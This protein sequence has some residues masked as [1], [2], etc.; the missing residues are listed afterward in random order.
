[1]PRERLFRFLTF[2]QGAFPIVYITRELFALL[3][4]GIV[5]FDERGVQHTKGVFNPDHWTVERDPEGF[6][7]LGFEATRSDLQKHEY[8][9]GPYRDR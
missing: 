3:P 1:M 5:L 2:R 4:D 6:M 7:L 9:T 8:F